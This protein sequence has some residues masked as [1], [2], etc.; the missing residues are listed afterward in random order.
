MKHMT[1]FIMVCVFS[2]RIEDKI[3]NNVQ[4]KGNKFI[5]R[6]IKNY[7]FTNHIFKVYFLPEEL[8]LSPRGFNKKLNIL[9]TKF[10]RGA[11]SIMYMYV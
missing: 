9:T 5:T 3:F 6:F 7:S 1:K 8:L 4:Q 10:N 11:N 2:T